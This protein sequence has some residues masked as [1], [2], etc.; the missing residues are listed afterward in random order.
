VLG[1]LEDAEYAQYPDEDEGAALARRLAVAVRLLDDE[2]D[3]ERDDGDDVED[4]HDAEAEAALRR[5]RDETQQELDGEPRHADR[6]H[7]EERVLVVRPH[8]LSPPQQQ[9]A[10][11]STPVY[12][13]KKV[14]INVK[15]LKFN[16]SILHRVSKNATPIARHNFDTH[17][18]I[19][20]FFGTNVTDEVGNQKALCYATS[21]NLCFCS[22]W[23]NGE[24]RKS[25]FSLNG[26][27]CTHNA[28]VH[29]LPE[30]KKCHL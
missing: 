3:E 7:H 8:H 6:L 11:V 20:I 28:P 30:I 13:S 24:T 26:L 21:N 14:K 10:V 4:V 12:Y 18:L 25:H 9:P 16:K 22:T 2:D 19:L 5:A 29:C 15:P 17:E 27:C 1:Q 23:Q